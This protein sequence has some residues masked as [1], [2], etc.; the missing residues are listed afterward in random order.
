MADVTVRVKLDSNWKQKVVNLSSV[1]DGLTNEA[2]RLEQKANALCSG[3]R[4]GIWH[5][6]E[7]GVKKGDTPAVY[8]MK[9]AQRY[10][11]GPVAIVYTKN[12]AAQKDNLKNN[13][14]AKVL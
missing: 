2:E 14:L 6:P 12:Y 10:G 1:K 7:T 5:D 3:F 4:S 13:T 9:T 8:G 11:S